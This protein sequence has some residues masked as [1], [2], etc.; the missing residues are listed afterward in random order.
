V[1]IPVLT[2]PSLP[3]PI[4]ESLEITQLLISSYPS[5]C[6]KAHRETIRNLLDDLH[7]IEYLSLSVDPAQFP[8][9]FVNEDLETLR[10]ADG[11]SE[12]Y[13]RALEWKAVL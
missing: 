7:N 12:E 10:K 11:I 5:L 1:Q 13:R 4:T 3:L 8:D 6:P 2:S 9:G